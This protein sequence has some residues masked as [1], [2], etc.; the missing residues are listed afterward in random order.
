ML[1]QETAGAEVAARVTGSIEWSSSDPKIASMTDGVVKPE[2]DGEA[3]ITA[4]FG[5]K[6]ATAK[7]VVT[8][9]A[10]GLSNAELPQQPRADLRQDGL[11]LRLLSWRLGGQGGLPALAPRV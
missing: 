10:T 9:M 11:Q 4:N 5:G 7:V 1:L 8:G 6:T 2:G 3:I